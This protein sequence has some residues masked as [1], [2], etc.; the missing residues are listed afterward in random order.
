MHH[1]E[2]SESIVDASCIA[3]CLL[4]SFVTSFCCTTE[5]WLLY[6]L[7]KFVILYIS[8]LVSTTTAAAAGHG[9]AFRELVVLLDECRF[10]LGF[11]SWLFALTLHTTPS[12]FVME[13]LGW[14]CLPHLFSTDDFAPS[15]TTVEHQCIIGRLANTHCFTNRETIA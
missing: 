10:Q 3:S 9:P 2:S 14:G 4:F 12:I 8:A 13:S 11:L 5:N 6:R 15:P 7:G 1:L